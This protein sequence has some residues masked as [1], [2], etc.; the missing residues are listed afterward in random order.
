MNSSKQYNCVLCK[1]RH[2]P[3]ERRKVNSDTRKILE[4]HFALFDISDSAVICNKCSHICYKKK[5]KLQVHPQ[6]KVMSQVL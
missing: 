5:E 6:S 3:K 1:K 2:S 4:R